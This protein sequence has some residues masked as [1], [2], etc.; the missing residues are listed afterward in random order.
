[1]FNFFTLFATGLSKARIVSLLILIPVLSASIVHAQQQTHIVRAGETLFSI[2][3]QYEVSVQ[4]IREWNELPD[5]T[6]RVGQRLIVS[7]DTSGP[8]HSEKPSE[9][10][11]Y[12]TVEAGQTLFRISRM[13]DV[14]IEDIRK[15]NQ[16]PGNIISIGQVLTIK[17]TDSPIPADTLAEVPEDGTP[18]H[19]DT[20][21]TVGAGLASGEED[22]D[23]TDLSAPDDPGFVEDEETAWY[24][25][26]SGETLYSIARDHDM[27]VQELMDINNLDTTQ[28]PVG[29]KLR[30]R[31]L[32]SAPPSVAADWDFE[33]SPQGRFVRYTLR[34]DDVIEQLL[35]YHQMDLI[36]F[37]ALNTGVLLSDLRPG[38]QVILLIPA[39]SVRKNPY[40]SLAQD[41]QAIRMAADKYPGDRYGTTTT[42]GDLYN[43]EALTAA[44][45]TLP[46]GSVTFI[47]NPENGYGVFVLINDRTSENT[48][49][50]SRAAFEAL[51]YTET[52]KRIANLK[53][54]KSP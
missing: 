39:T 4:Q 54:L 35:R 41:P 53:E 34:E 48:V 11:I 29:F 1:M 52:G 10:K 28:L 8:D 19:H 37:R 45:P 24:T 26:R 44:H 21:D 14:S 51:G 32:D 42:S 49:I 38:D 9:Q 2:S 3:R 43:P 13:Y 16:L 6:I 20:L 30:I 40:R 22:A 27:T 15:W 31:R 23:T 47:Q 46:L 25:V 18:D 50:L 33:S 7:P 5:N 12:H 36:E 17:K